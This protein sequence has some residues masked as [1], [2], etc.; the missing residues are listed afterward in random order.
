M[1]IVLF[2]LLSVSV[3]A[4]IKIGN[5][6][7]PDSIAEAYFLDCYIH[8]DTIVERKDF[9]GAT[10]SYRS[11][12]EE[13]N[14]ELAKSSLSGEILKTIHYE[15]HRDT[16]YEGGLLYAATGM[17]DKEI[18]DYNKKNRGKIVSIESI[19][20]GSYR[21]HTG[22]FLVPRK[23][24]EIDFIKYFKNKICTTRVPQ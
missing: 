23:P 18:N 21:R 4:Q 20:A 5:I 1:K 7:L 22:K 24:S 6:T 3:T 8:P 19:P 10:V 15:A 13:F 12:M 11:A 14:R 17:T 2:L 16:T 9:A